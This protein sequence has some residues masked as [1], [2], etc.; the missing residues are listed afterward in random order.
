[1]TTRES[2]IAELLV[3]K[4]QAGD[5]RAFDELVARYRTRIYALALHMTGSASDA[6]DVTQDVFM[7]AYRALGQFAGKSE[8][9]TWLYR[10][11]L[12]QCLTTRR[13]SGRMIP[14]DDTRLSL[15][16]EVDADGDPWR[17][18]DLRRTYRQLIT[19]FDGLPPD[20]KTAVTLVILQGFSHAECAVIMNCAEGTI[21]WRIHQARQ[22]L[23]K[24]LASETKRRGEAEAP[25]LSLIDGLLA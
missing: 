16:L 24:Q 25:P 6:D 1:M 18:I 11:A 4:A 13:R 22:R 7:K 20:I 2:A 9:F 19:A 21:S 23:R 15:A 8:F 10:I 17:A 3:G 12:N 14:T 5:R